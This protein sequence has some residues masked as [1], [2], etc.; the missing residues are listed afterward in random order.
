MTGLVIVLFSKLGYFM[1]IA[2]IQI[3]LQYVVTLSD[4]NKH[5]QKLDH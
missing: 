5:I 1:N 2:L 4:R 3:A